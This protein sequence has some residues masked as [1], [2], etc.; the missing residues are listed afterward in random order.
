MNQSSNHKQWVK[1]HRATIS[2]HMEV[3]PEQRPSIVHFLYGQGFLCK[4]CLKNA[5]FQR[6]L[7]SLFPPSAKD[8]FALLFLFPCKFEVH[9]S[10][11]KQNVRNKNDQSKQVGPEEETEYRLSQSWVGRSFKYHFKLKRS[12]HSVVKIGN[13]E[14]S[15][16]LVVYYQVLDWDLHSYGPLWTRG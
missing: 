10:I 12:N 5:V 9:H 6:R 2:R 15:C 16:N 8:A 3:I 1:E 11:L 4:S 7:A 13:Q 14:K